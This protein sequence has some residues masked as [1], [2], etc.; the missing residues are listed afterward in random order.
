MTVPYRRLTVSVPRLR[1][2]D[3]IVIGRHS[4]FV[5]EPKCFAGWRNSYPTA[6]VGERE[7]T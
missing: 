2:A 3:R 6:S 7:R 4:P 5:V 1:D